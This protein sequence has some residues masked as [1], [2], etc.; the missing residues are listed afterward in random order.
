[1]RKERHPRGPGEIGG[2]AG[3]EGPLSSDMTVSGQG[4]ALSEKK[5]ETSMA[6]DF[7]HTPGEI[8]GKGG[9]KTRE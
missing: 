4:G 1:M 2:A 7:F 8:G 9:S 5:G 3:R 6:R